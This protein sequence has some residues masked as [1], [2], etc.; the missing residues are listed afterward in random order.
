MGAAAAV[1][2]QHAPDATAKGAG[3]SAQESGNSGQLEEIV[4]TAQKRSE[5]LQQ[6]PVSAV[7]INNQAMVQE[8][9]NSLGALSETVPSVHISFHPRSGDLYIRGIG[10]GENQDFEQ[11]V[12]TFID[13]I[14]HGR[15]RT[16]AATFLDLDRVEILKGPQSTYFGNNAIAGALNIVTKKPGD[17]FD[18]SARALY[19]QHGQ[20]ALEGAVGGPLNDIVGIRFAAAANGVDGWIKNI[21][22]GDHQPHEDNI[23]GRVT[24]VFKPTEDFDAT[25]K[26][27]GSKDKRRDGIEYGQI[28]DCPP[29]APFVATGFC[30]AALA[31]GV[32]TGIDNNRN[33]TKPGAGADLNTAETVLTA[34][35]RQW[36]HTFTSVTGYF[37]YHFTDNL[38]G[39]GT[40][41]PLLTSQ[42][43]EHYHQ[44]SQEFR[45]TSPVGQRFEY[46][47]G[48]YFQ[49]D[50][51]YY[52]QDLSY[53]F[54]N[55]VISSAPPLLPLVPY[56]PLGQRTSLSQ[57]SD[58]YAG[59]GSV[60]WN[61]TDQLKLTGGLRGSWVKKDYQWHN[62]FGTAT[63]TYGS[64][65]SLPAA[66]QPLASAIGI[67]TA[68]HLS[69]DRSDHAWLPS[70]KLQYQID[71]RAMAYVSYSKGFK[72][73]GFNGAD[74]SAVAANLPFAPEHVNAYEAGLKTQWFD[75]SVLL[76]LAVY[77]ANYDDLQVAVNINTGGNIRSLVQNAG[78]SVSQGAEL[79]GQWVISKAFRLAA[80]VSYDDA[81]YVNYRNVSPTQLQILQGQA[82][83]DLSGRPT[84]FAPR[85]SGNLTGSHRALLPDNFALTTELMAY[86]SSR[87][88]LDGTDDPTVAQSSYVR[89]DGRLSLEKS[90]GRWAV[91]LIGKNL[92]DRDVLSFAQAMPLS[93]GSV[94]VQKEQPRNVAI[95]FRYHY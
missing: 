10:S 36:D 71:P 79:E 28:I 64:V 73:G 20:Y 18:A 32:P 42:A 6:V 16:T 57:N 67:G 38:D 89:L 27:E 33:A 21:N 53:F 60:S 87:Y 58:A 19:G 47:G 62:F 83:Q 55:P 37:E 1:L 72:S 24:L 5:N 77:R 12:G 26:V 23:A 51:L 44:F 7:V 78:S 81:H 54:L 52:Q 75:D 92:T 56:L 35:Y 59:F 61:L 15:A 93:L 85:W 80:N 4:V 82:T 30:S 68:G 17:T 9:L 94:A 14:Y 11:S 70:A 90:D 2:A 91:D 43:P 22:A 46:L 48:I 8:N 66:L 29:P 39:D 25:F 86:G 84:Y 49:T 13:D 50:Y 3:R 63:E 40:P 74:Q 69:G 45:V 88:F 95:Q 31:Q 41:T 34:N 65:V 76:N